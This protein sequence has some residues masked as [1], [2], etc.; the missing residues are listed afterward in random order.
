MPTNGLTTLGKLERIDNTLQE[1]KE[2]VLLLGEANKNRDIKVTE[3]EQHIKECRKD[4][5]ELKQIEIGR[6]AVTERNSKVLMLVGMVATIF[7]VYLNYSD[8]QAKAREEY[9]K[10]VP[11]PQQQKII[12]QQAKQLE[13]LLKK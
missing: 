9:A 7:A 5:D 4:I 13:E 8:K 2:A 12:Q 10:S 6:K 3:L 11:S 1:V